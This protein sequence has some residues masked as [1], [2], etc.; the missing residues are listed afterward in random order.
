M[1]FQLKHRCTGISPQSCEISKQL[2]QDGENTEWRRKTENKC[3]I[4]KTLTKRRGKRKG[5]GSTQWKRK[6]DQY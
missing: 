1:N 5:N 3:L 2:L 4:G 6:K